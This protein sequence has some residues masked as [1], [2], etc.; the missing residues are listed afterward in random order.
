MWCTWP[1][2]LSIRP[3]PTCPT[4]PNI[5]ILLREL[6]AESGVTP[7]PGLVEQLKLYLRELRAWNLKINLTGLRTVEE[8]AVKH[9]GDT[10]TLLP[11]IPGQVCTVLDVG[12]GA[13]VP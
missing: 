12:T 2:C 10:L 11:V 3:L 1:S 4:K 5:D 8:M 7:S 9:I 13:G 6:L